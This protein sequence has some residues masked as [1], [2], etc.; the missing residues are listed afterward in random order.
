MEPL[1][2]GKVRED[3]RTHHSGRLDSLFY[4]GYTWYIPDEEVC[5]PNE[6]Y[7]KEVGQ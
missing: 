6:N 5:E 3:N 7:P 1:V 4:Q 2:D